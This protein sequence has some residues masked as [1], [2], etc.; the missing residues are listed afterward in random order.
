VIQSGGVGRTAVNGSG[1]LWVIPGRF[2]CRDG[3][4]FGGLEQPGIDRGIVRD[5]EQDS[6]LRF[7]R[8]F[9]KRFEQKLENKKPRRGWTAKGK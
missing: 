2:K 1:A 7:E 3:L 9:A 4:G 6:D 5:P 8:D